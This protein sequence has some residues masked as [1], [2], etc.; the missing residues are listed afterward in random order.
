MDSSQI[1]SLILEVRKAF[2]QPLRTDVRAVIDKDVWHV[3][4][5][6]VPNGKVIDLGGGYSPASAVLAKLGVDVT[7]V[8]TFAS[9]KVYEQFS[10]QQ[11]CDVL[12]SFGVKVE[13]IDLR[14][15]DPTKVFEA[16]SI[17]S[18][19]CFGAIYLFNPRQLLDRCMRVLKPGGKLVVECN[20][21]VT[22][23]SRIRV[24]LGRNNTSAFQEYF[25]EDVHKRFWVKS[26][27]RALAAY[28]KLSEYHLLGRNWSVY[29]SRD[30]FPEIALTLADHALRP[31][32]GLCND[33]YLIGTK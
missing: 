17:D 13:K 6:Y 15:Y 11:L 24:L 8:D 7:V 22:L 30:A 26:D 4:L 14:E 2:P 19:D 9:S 16:A 32:P 3:Q 33:I 28:L 12:G 10:A 31:F 18:V 1:R 21:A 20:N 27:V 5:A 25:F 23:L 29:Q